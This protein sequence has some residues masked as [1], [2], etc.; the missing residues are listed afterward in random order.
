M[1]TVRR[2]S[3]GVPQSKMRI[4]FLLLDQSTTLLNIY[5]KSRNV[6][7]EFLKK[8]RTYL[9]LFRLNIFV[10]CK[11]LSSHYW[12]QDCRLILLLR[13]ELVYTDIIQQISFSVCSS[14]NDHTFST[15]VQRGLQYE[16]CITAL[17]LARLRANYL[18]ICMK[19]VYIHRQK[20]FSACCMSHQ[21]ITNTWY[22][23]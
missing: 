12:R 13:N 17:I 5:R 4:I 22:I 15:K 19:D 21:S 2:R 1:P 8:E 18:E 14:G 7:Y 6:T 10:T 23:Y 9:I 3:S 11:H 20:I 16:M